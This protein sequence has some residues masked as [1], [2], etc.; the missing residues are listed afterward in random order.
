MSSDPAP[1]S[2]AAPSAPRP[3]WPWVIAVTALCFLPLGLV[4]AYFAWRTDRAVAAGNQAA[5]RR[6][7][8]AARGWTIGAAVVGLIVN[9]IIITTFMVLGA[10]GR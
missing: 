4:A 2:A 9:A 7:A 10:F 8:R 6:A 5:A 1:S 3:G